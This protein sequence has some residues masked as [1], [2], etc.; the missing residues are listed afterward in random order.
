[1]YP[2][3]PN[4]TKV[5]TTYLAM[6]MPV[7]RIQRKYPWL[8]LERANIPKI[9]R[10]QL[11]ET[12][13]PLPPLAPSKLLSLK[14]KQNKSLVNANRELIERFEKKIRATVGRVWD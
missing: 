3:S 6:Y 13:I 8:L 1:M 10:A 12:E 5:Q 9:N 4:R 14:S 2:L 7:S 11:F